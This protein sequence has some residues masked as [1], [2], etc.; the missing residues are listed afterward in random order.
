MGFGFLHLPPTCLG[1]DF[2][3]AHGLFATTDE[4][5]YAL[6]PWVCIEKGGETHGFI[7]T[8]TCK[9]LIF[10]TEL[11]VHPRASSGSDYQFSVEHSDL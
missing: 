8:T 1:D 3:E 10:H 4:I 2:W 6:G 5:P 7:G 9:Y 11:V